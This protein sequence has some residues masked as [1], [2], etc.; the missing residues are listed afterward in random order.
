MHVRMKSK[1]QIKRR[2]T[3]EEKEEEEEEELTRD[4]VGGGRLVGK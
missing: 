4:R 3:Q 2:R 1:N